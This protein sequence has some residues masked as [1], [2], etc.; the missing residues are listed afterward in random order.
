MRLLLLTAASAAALALAGCTADAADTQSA[1]T[2][3]VDYMAQ[4]SAAVANAD[5]P[6]AARALDESR[7]PVETL[8]WLGLAPG[9]DAA[10]LVPG[11]GYWTEIMAHVVGPQ[12]SVVGLQP[13][14][15][16]TSEDDAKAWLKQELGV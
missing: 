8:A 15:F 3:A 13:N 9:M 16:Y 7:K 14:Q 5:R 11:E 12:G 10:D 4:I 2:A 6:E 1:E